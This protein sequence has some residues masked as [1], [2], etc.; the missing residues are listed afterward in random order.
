MEEIKFSVTVDSTLPPISEQYVSFEMGEFQSGP[1]FAYEH[2][3]DR[4]LPEAPGALT[5]FY[6]DLISGAPFPLVLALHRVSAVDSVIAA[7]LFVKRDI[8]ILPSTLGFV[9]S[10]D[11]Y[12]RKGIPFL[13]HSDPMLSRF[14]QFLDGYFPPN[15]PKREVGDRLASGVQWVYEYLT[16]GR[17]PHLGA[18]QEPPRILEIGSNG[19]VLADATNP[20]KNTW[21]DLYRRGFLYGFVLGSEQDGTRKVVASKKSHFLR[22]DLL[23]AKT[24]LDELESAF[25]GQPGWLL[26]GYFLYSPADGSVIPPSYML[27]V[28]LRV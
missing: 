28:F 2:H 21:V 10:V 8:T 1:C 23:K 3:G 26:D 4:F 27:Q 18:D 25:G 17:L 7:A 24:F 9:A 22:F 6:E 16:E 5:R 20:T 12:H 19:F 11:L 14:V 13:G 15:L